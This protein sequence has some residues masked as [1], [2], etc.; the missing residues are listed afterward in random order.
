MSQ[1]NDGSDSSGRKPDVNLHGFGVECSW[2][3]PEK[4]SKRMNN[5]V[6]FFW[7]QSDNTYKSKSI[8]LYD[9]EI[10]AVCNIL[11][12]FLAMVQLKKE[13][14]GIDDRFGDGNDDKGDRGKTQDS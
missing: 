14:L 8:N 7:K 9:S 2:W 10:R 1:K 4:A 6:R 3:I 13:E 11:P 12:R 5:K